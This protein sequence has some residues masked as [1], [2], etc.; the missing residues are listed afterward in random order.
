MSNLSLDP[1][2]SAALSPDQVLTIPAGELAGYSAEALF[3]FKNDAADLL[4]IAK[5]IVDHI[6]RA[7]GLKYADRAQQLRLAAGKDTGVIH[8]DDGRVRITADLAKKVAWDQAR[9]AQLA[10]QIAANGDDPSEYLE[11][12]YRVPET[13]FN[14][15]PESIRSAFVPA[16]TLKAGKPSFRLALLGGDAP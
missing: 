8:F 3:Q 6:D 16:R 10:Q 5:G 4:G 9:L 12:I 2:G 11:V 1:T 14:A 15:W 7:L 13:R